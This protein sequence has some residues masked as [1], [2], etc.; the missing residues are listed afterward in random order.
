[1]TQAVRPAILLARP[2]LVQHQVIATAV[3]LVMCLLLE[4]ASLLVQITFM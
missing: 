3:H 4:L 2:A 1:M